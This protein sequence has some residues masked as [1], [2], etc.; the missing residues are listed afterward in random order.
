MAAN[1]LSRNRRKITSIITLNVIANFFFFCSQHLACLAPVAIATLS[2]CQ[3][4][5]T[6][7]RFP[8][9]RV[10]TMLAIVQV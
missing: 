5:D 6:A 3:D 8:F 1:N 10:L 7:L 9:S 4:C 2:D